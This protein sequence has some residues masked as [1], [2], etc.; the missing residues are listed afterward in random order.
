MTNQAPGILGIYF[1]N[2][3]LLTVVASTILVFWYRWTVARSMR[4][5]SGLAVDDAWAD[6][7]PPA[8]TGLRGRTVIQGPETQ[9]AIHEVT[10][11]RLRL[12]VIYGLAGL[13]AA[14]VLTILSLVALGSEFR[15]IGKLVRHDKAN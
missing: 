4:R 6:E 1:A 12:A 7:F 15:A 8:T 3:I 14:A 2:A 5:T 10:P 13:A 9:R 11:L